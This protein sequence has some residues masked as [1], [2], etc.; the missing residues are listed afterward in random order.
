[1]IF[2]VINS[3]VINFFD[4]KRVE[5]GLWKSGKLILKNESK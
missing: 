4:E 5:D 1:M 3:K 2:R